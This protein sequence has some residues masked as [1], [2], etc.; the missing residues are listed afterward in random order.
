MSGFGIEV[1]VHHEPDPIAS[2][3]GRR[4]RVVI[5]GGPDVDARLD[6]IRSLRD[7][8]DFFVLGTEPDLRERFEAAEVPY[9]CYP[10]ERRF[11]LWSDVR[12]T[13]AV[14]R[15]LRGWPMDIAHC[16]DTKPAIFGRIAA[17]RAGVPCVVATLPGL[18]GLYASDDLRT[19][20]RR[21][22]FGHGH[23]LASQVSRLTLFQN[24][25]DPRRLVDDGWISADRVEVIPGSGVDGERFRPRPTRAEIRD[26]LGVDRHSR[27]IVM[28]S[29]LLRTKGV[30]ELAELAR[31]LRSSRSEV[32][33][34]LIGGREGVEL[35]GLTQAEEQQ[36]EQSV[37]WIGPRTDVERWLAGADLLVH[38]SYYREGIPRIVVEAAL[39]GCPVVA[40]DIPGTREVVRDGETGWL[41]PA[42]DSERFFSA[43][44]AALGRPEEAGRRA[45]RLRADA[46]ERFE[47]R[48]IVA[49]H[50]E[51]YRRL[52][53]ERAMA[54]PARPNGARP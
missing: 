31:R 29:R 53:A 44:Q 43:V 33:V 5:I 47:L 14:A 39:C 40:T 7:E 28:V 37:R 13:A 23:L 22:L 6:L 1:S 36:L 34:V 16:F 3:P 48:T 12:S 11:D 4:P 9:R 42:R 38:P 17:W 49:R 30:L 32:T 41:V 19:R 26:E 8:F 45:A 2:T 21:Y 24:P 51:L 27:V 20:W 46:G 54:S 10:L 18:G 15:L 50:R 25:D 35:G 52:L